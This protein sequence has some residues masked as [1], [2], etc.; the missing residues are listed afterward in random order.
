MLNV[1]IHSYTS[2]ITAIKMYNPSVE[3]HSQ[4]FTKLLKLLFHPSCDRIT[5]PRNKENNLAEGTSSN[6]PQSDFYIEWMR[7]T[8]IVAILVGMYLQRI[9][10]STALYTF[11]LVCVTVCRERK[12]LIT[13]IEVIF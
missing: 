3:C 11:P 6:A 10:I 12:T 9:D 5:Q 1:F 2:Q 7:S 13:F 8:E 4:A